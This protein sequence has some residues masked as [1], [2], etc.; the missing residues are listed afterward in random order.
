MIQLSKNFR[1]HEFEDSETAKLHKI[2]NKVP[3]KAILYNLIAL[4]E[5]VLQPVRDKFGPIEITSGYRCEAL[6]L[7]VKGSQ[8][9]DHMLGRA[10]DIRPIKGDI[11]DVYEWIIKELEF[12]QCLLETRKSNG[13]TWIHV[14]YKRPNRNEA[15]RKE[16]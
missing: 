3:N 6:N 8:T 13:S 9:S 1:L 11:K 14:S 10:A 5:A 2:N 12:D 4:C 16:V 7:A 15:I